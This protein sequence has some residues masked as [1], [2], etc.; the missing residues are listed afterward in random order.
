VEGL[1]VRKIKTTIK[2]QCLKEKRNILILQIKHEGYVK[3][4]HKTL[5]LL[6]RF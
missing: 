1:N 3:Y 5:I 6:E 4:M 2:G